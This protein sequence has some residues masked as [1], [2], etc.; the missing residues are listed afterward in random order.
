[1]SGGTS[2]APR[3]S[4]QSPAVSA[5]FVPSNQTVTP[6]RGRDGDNAAQKSKSAFLGDNVV[7]QAVGAAGRNDLVDLI[8]PA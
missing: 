7:H 2:G 5:S 8:S 4:V 3:P 6:A 1:M